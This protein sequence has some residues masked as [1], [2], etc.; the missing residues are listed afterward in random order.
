MGNSIRDEI[1]TDNWLQC[2]QQGV[3]MLA[4]EKGNILR[5]V[6]GYLKP[7]VDNYRTDHFREISPDERLHGDFLKKMYDN[8]D[9][10]I[11]RG[12]KALEDEFYKILENRRQGPKFADAFL[13][14]VRQIFE[15]ASD[16]FRRE[17]DKIWSPKESERQRQ[18]EAALQDITE[19]KDKFGVTKQAKMEEYC[20]SALIGLEGCLTATIQRKARGIGLEVISRL[21]EHLTV[22]ERRF[23]RWTQKLI[24]ARD[25]YQEKANRQ[26]ESADALVIKGLSYMT[27]RNLMVYIRI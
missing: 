6:D 24:Q 9:Q 14:T 19:F 27:D 2:T 20:D 8:R 22:L 25:L 10:L 15:D 21:Q 13:A 4:S 17:Q 23:N 12:R 18:Y 7:K 5:F 16:K 1:A 26:A 3:K 11:K